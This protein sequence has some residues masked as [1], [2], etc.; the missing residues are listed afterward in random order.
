M[1]LQVSGIFRLNSKVRDAWGVV[2]AGCTSSLILHCQHAQCC[3][4]VCPT[5]PIFPSLSL[6]F[7][8]RQHNLPSCPSPTCGGLRAGLEESQTPPATAVGGSPLSSSASRTK[9]MSSGGR[10][11]LGRELEETHVQKW[12]GEG[13]GCP[14]ACGIPL[15]L[16]HSTW[17]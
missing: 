11:G 15:V 8:Q 10:W 4:T 2:V 17:G 6:S 9:H 12:D 13:T 3:V 5:K 16:Q 1:V 7:E 14:R